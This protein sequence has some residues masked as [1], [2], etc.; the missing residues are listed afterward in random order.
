MLPNSPLYKVKQVSY[1]ELFT[2]F[3]LNNKKSL[4]PPFAG[5]LRVF[6]QFFTLEE[7]TAQIYPFLRSH[8]SAYEGFRH[9]G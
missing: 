3:L 7:E 5:Y 8:T 4:F 9:H 2:L 1:L 6:I